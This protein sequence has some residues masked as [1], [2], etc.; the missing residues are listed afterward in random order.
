MLPGMFA[1]KN[2]AGSTCIFNLN[3]STYRICYCYEW[4]IY[5]KLAELAVLMFFLQYIP[6]PIATIIM[7]Y[8]RKKNNEVEKEGFVL[9]LGYIFPVLA[10][11]ISFYHH[12]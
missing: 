2:N 10:L 4:N 8:R 5:T 12:L 9:P 6:T 1:R 7:K 3:L 11:A